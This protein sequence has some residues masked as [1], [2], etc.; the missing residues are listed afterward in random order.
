MNQLVLGQT[1]QHLQVQEGAGRL[2]GTRGCTG[3]QEHALPSP[4]PTGKMQPTLQT[5]A[6]DQRLAGNQHFIEL[7]SP[8]RNL[9]Q[10]ILFTT[11]IMDTGVWPALPLLRTI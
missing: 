3:G 2:C 8:R 1:H 9:F 7:S 5:P 11:G 6:E 4:N 10:Q